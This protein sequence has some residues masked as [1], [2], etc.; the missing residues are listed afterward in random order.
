MPSKVQGQFKVPLSLLFPRDDQQ[1]PAPGSG[2]L[3]NK[4]S[5][6]GKIP[7]CTPIGKTETICGWHQKVQ[8][9]C[10]KLGAAR[11]S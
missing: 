10:V 5:L 3:L 4:K 6:S 1:P 7:C 11:V 9:K 2:Q 8:G